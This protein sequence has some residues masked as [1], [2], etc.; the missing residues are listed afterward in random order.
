M[1]RRCRGST[2]LPDDRRRLQ[3][4]RC[5]SHDLIENGLECIGEVKIKEL[6]TV[7]EFGNT[8]GIRC[9]PQRSSISLS[10]QSF[11][12][13]YSALDGFLGFS[14]K[15]REMPFFLIHTPRNRAEFTSGTISLSIMTVSRA[16][17]H[18]CEDF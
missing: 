16:F 1:R 6:N 7:C 10:C 5:N 4:S 13:V 8:H 12:I 14:Y 15:D 11:Y 9:F 17:R 2:P 3:C 18:L